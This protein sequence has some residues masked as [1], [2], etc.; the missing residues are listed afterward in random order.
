MSQ[1]VDAK[2]TDEQVSGVFED[3]SFKQKAKNILS[4]KQNAEE[5]VR[6][7]SK[8]LEKIPKIGSYFSDVPTLCLMVM[9]YADG[10]YK[11]IPLVTMLGIVIA[12]VYFLSPIDI[13]PDWFPGVGHVDDLAIIGLAIDAAHNDIKDYK[14]WKGL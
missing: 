14:A 2:L 9:D 7:I 3:E 4:N 12:L 11:K 10:S 6:D 13:I 8:K 5:F 1:Y